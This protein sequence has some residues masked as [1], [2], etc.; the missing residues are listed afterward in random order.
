MNNYQ[1]AIFDFDGT[2]CDSEPAITNDIK[3]TFAH[4]KKEAPS[5]THIQT[6]MSNGVGMVDTFKMLH[7]EL[8]SL[9]MD[10]VNTWL[11]TYREIAKETPRPLFQGAEEVIKQLK[12]E[13]IKV[14]IASNNIESNIIKSLKNNNL[15]KEVDLVLGISDEYPMKPHPDIFNHHILPQYSAFP[16]NDFIMVGDT[17]TDIQ[18]AQNSGIDSCWARFG[19]GYEEDCQALGPNYTISNITDVLPILLGAKS[20][21]SR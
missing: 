2:L 13:Q 14:V 11:D 15:D 1:V 7:P 6:V 9:N 10:E 16:L 17:A 18:F 12:Q 8:M 21:I 3:K 19:I 4:F 5:D 20:H